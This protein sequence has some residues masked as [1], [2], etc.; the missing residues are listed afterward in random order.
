KKLLAAKER[1]D[2]PLDEL[3]TR[4][5]AEVKRLQTEFKATAAK[6][7]PKRPATDVQGDLQKDHPTPE[8]V[9][10]ETQAS[11]SGLRKFLVDKNLVSLPSDSVPKVQEPPPSMR[12]TTLASMDTPGPFEKNVKEAFYN[13]TLP[14]KDWPA[15]QTEDYLRGAFARTLI[16]IVSIHEAFPGHYVQ[17]IWVPLVKS[18]VRKFEDA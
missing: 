10:P 13:V 5:E 1:I 8:K 15:A 6:I 16:D 7:D 14:E 3:L 4:A 2:A 18:K 12:A 9:I 11:L 17:F